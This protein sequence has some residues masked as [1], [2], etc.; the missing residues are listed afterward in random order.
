MTDVPIYLVT[1]HLAPHDAIGNDLLGMRECLAGAGYR[2]EAYAAEVHPSLAGVARPLSAAGDEFRKNPKALLI[3]HHSAGWA[4]GEEL[5]E[6]SR[7]RIAVK[8][9]NVTPPRFFEPYSD[10][11]TQASRGGE[12]ATGR[13][14]GHRTALFWGDSSFNCEDLVRY[15]APR[16]RCRVLAPFHRTE[17]LSE[18]ELDRQ[19]LRRYQGAPGARILFVGGV[20]PN[21]G[22]LQL[23]RVLAAYRRKYDP[24]ARLF[25]VGGL[26][27]R[28]SSY[29][30]HLKDAVTAHGLENNVVFTG[31]VSAA[32]LRSYFLM[33]DAFLCLSEHE[34]FCVPLIEAMFFRS[35]IVA[36]ASTAIPE[37][38]G[39]AGLLWPED[40]LGCF[41]ESIAA[42][43]GDQAIR[44]GFQ[45]KGWQRFQDVYRREAVSAQLL[46]L[47]EEALA[48]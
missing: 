4:A 19:V 48:G 15:G 32:A 16:D 43:T 7:N 17:Q 46:R 21:K 36:A 23:L 41:V 30:S 25:L 3:Y 24:D 29:T 6:A 27:P 5:L 11:F 8:Y 42:C 14:A 34:G 33:S 12:A 45:E 18:V 31:G 35:P 47:V 9:H 28:L 20:K 10:E 22:H 44:R 26:D 37:T 1:I 39:D 38:V 13:V 40:E 2:V